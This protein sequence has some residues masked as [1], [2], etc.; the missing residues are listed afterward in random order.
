MCFGQMEV[1]AAASPTPGVVTPADLSVVLVGPPSPDYVARP[2][3]MVGSRHIGPLD[4][5]SIVAESNGSA[6]VRAELVRQE[7]TRGYR[8]EWVQ[9]GTA[10][11]LIEKVEE[12][13]LNAGAQDHLTRSRHAD[14]I[15]KDFHGFF[16]TGQVGS[17]SA[18][19]VRLV[20]PDNF[21]TDNV[22]FV[23]GNLLLVVAAGRAGQ[24]S[25]ELARSQARNEYA[26][27][28]DQTID[29]TGKPSSV[30]P[31]GLAERRLNLAA[32]AI[33]LGVA[34]ALAIPALLLIVIAARRGGP[35]R[36]RPF[37]SADRRYWWDGSTWRDTAVSV[38]DG[39]PRSPDGAHWFDG[40]VWRPVAPPGPRP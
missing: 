9:R 14:Q 15:G 38:P 17:D 39:A 2:D 4:L 34:L 26:A 7:F 31:P 22:V 36:T 3:G 8:R 10:A 13:R 24:A 11:V 33:A 16:D 32:V 12:F 23:K 37:L 25:V 29:Q 40:A 18:Y 27:A 6:A 21:E 19:G 28:P 35:P 20:D 30:P 5:Q 1:A